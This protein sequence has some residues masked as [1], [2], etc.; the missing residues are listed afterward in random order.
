MTDL[1]IIKNMSLPRHPSGP[2]TDPA[3]HPDDGQLRG[4]RV[5]LPCRGA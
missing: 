1:M 3:Q 5:R 2:A 4:V